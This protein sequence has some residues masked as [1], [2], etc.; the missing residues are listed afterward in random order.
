MI[1]CMI[2]NTDYFFPMD[3][4]V[5]YMYHGRRVSKARRYIILSCDR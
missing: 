2:D 3:L 1:F 4:E 5:M